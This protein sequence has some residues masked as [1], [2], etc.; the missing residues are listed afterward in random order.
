[1]FYSEI[2]VTT[3]GLVLDCGAAFTPMLIGAIVMLTKIWEQPKC[4]ST[5]EKSKKKKEERKKRKVV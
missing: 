5:D 4:L 3:G 1:M 2:Q